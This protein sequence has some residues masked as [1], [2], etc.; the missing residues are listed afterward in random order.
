MPVLDGWETARMLRSD[1]RTSGIP[2]IAV[3][4]SV[5]D[6]DQGLRDELGFVAVWPKPLAPSRLLEEVRGCIGTV[7]AVA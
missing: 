3:S 5:L 7:G 6:E 1:P 2:L 4:A